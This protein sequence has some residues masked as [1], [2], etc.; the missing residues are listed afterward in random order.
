MVMRN[1]GKEV[2]WASG[3]VVAAMTCT[4]FFV[5]WQ[6]APGA[7]LVIAALFLVGLLWFFWFIGKA[8]DSQ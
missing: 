3:A 2:G 6:I 7:M 5:L 8:D 4:V 1:G